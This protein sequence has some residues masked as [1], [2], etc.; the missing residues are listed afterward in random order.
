M[1]GVEVSQCEEDDAANTYYAPTGSDH[2]HE[3]ARGITP[4][5]YQVP[6][7]TCHERGEPQWLCERPKRDDDEDVCKLTVDR[8]PE[9]RVKDAVRYLVL[10]V[11]RPIAFRHAIDALPDTSIRR[12]CD[13]VL[14][15]TKGDARLM[16]TS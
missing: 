5:A 11:D 7:L 13:A 8:S 4:N 16:L 14:S 10:C 12:I 2:Q 9:K 15:A 3:N 1:S 6:Q